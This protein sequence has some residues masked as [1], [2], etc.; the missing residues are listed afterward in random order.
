MKFIFN[1]FDITPLYVTKY[2][3]NIIE[4]CN[5]P[6]LNTGNNLLRWLKIFEVLILHRNSG[7]SW[8]T[9]VVYGDTQLYRKE[10]F[11]PKL[12]KYFKQA[13]AELGQA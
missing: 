11:E 4:F 9:T 5:T 13:E 2:T 8:N 10:I 7:V 1:I 6:L 12:W 3:I